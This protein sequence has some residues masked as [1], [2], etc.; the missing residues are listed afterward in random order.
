MYITGDLHGYTDI[1]KLN[2]KRFPKNKDLTKDDYVIVAGDFGLVWD[3]KNDELYWRKWLARKNFTT[4]FI[5]GNH[6]N[7]NMLNSYPVETWNG[8]KIHRVSDSIFHLMRGQIFTIKGYKIFTFGGAQSHDKEYRKENINWWPNEMPSTEEYQEGLKNLELHNWQVDF[9]ISH[10]CPTSTLQSL[11][12]THPTGIEQDQLSEYL[13]RI[14]GRLCYR[15]WYFGHFHKDIEL[16]DEQ[17]L[18]YKSIEEL[19]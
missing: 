2:S 16:P 11:N 18:I 1:S 12:D 10:M 3:N 9:V 4:L 7:F 15:K 19:F 8:G 5:D 17:K 13:E 6:E 14:K